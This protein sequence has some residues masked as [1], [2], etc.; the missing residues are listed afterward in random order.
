MRI[1][2]GYLQFRPFG[3]VLSESRSDFAPD[4]QL[5]P[6]ASVDPLFFP[7]IVVSD[8]LSRRINVRLEQWTITLTFPYHIVRQLVYEPRN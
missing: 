8:A 7:Y 2:Q 3:Y 4:V 5:I 1:L 6:P